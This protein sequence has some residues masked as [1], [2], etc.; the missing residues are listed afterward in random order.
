MPKPKTFFHDRLVLLIL[1]INTFLSVALILS[2]VFALSDNS[3]VYIREYRSNL[4]LDGYEAGGI[5]DI[6]AF[7]FFAVI[8]YGFQL[9][10]STKIYHIRKHLSLMILLITMVIFIFSLLVINALLGLK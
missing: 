6:M 1:S 2:V 10:A 9:Y 3:A 4:G 7:A 8:V 5:K